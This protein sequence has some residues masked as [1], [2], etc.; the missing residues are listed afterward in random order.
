MSA[1]QDQLESAIQ[2]GMGNLHPSGVEGMGSTVP[3][4][5]STQDVL[6]RVEELSQIVTENHQVT[7][8]LI[9]DTRTSVREV[10]D[11]QTTLE[12][13]FDNLQSLCEY[14]FMYTQEKKEPVM[15]EPEVDQYEQDWWRWF[16]TSTPPGLG[17][18]LSA[19]QPEGNPG[20]DASHV[21]GQSVNAGFGTRLLRKS[22][23]R[24]ARHLQR[25]LH[26]HR[27]EQQ[28]LWARFTGNT[29]WKMETITRRPAPQGGVGAN[30]GKWG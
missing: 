4:G 20:H 6:A 28:A 2:D 9:E 13:D 26:H 1:R 18:Q 14:H 21:S 19:Q 30:R 10:V 7:N 22:Q 15:A 24:V 29:L 11:K 5:P 3:V 8:R 12:Q 16:P 25:I 23:E 27:Q 17:G